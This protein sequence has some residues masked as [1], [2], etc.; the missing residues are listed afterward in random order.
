MTGVRGIP[1]HH[2]VVLF[3]IER[4]G[5]M[6]TASGVDF[7]EAKA[8]VDRK[9]DEMHQEGRGREQEAETSGFWPGA[10]V[11]VNELDA[12]D[13]AQAAHISSELAAAVVEHRKQHGP[14][15]SGP[16]IGSV[17]HQDRDGLMRLAAVADYSTGGRSFTAPRTGEDERTHRGAQ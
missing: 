14:F 10:P 7:D 16:D 6:A 12:P 11:A 15:H 2:N 9:L 5:C 13:L 4:D 1:P 17:A 3:A 8:N